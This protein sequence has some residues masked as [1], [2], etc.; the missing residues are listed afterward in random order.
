M[1]WVFLSI[2]IVSEVMATSAMK[3]SVGFTRPVPSVI[4]AGCFAVSLYFLSLTLKTLP[5][6]IAYAIWAGAGIVLISIIGLVVF[7][8]SL[9]AAAI[10][11]IA[12]IVSG[13][14]VINTLS[15]SVSH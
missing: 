8:Q 1:H 12:L 5:V 3:A 15:T 11:G 10:V 2:A 4:T 14:A 9:D 13:V 6:G 7:K